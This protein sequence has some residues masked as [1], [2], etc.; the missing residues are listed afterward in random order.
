MIFNDAV[1]HQGHTARLGFTRASTRAVAEVRMR[2]V[3]RRRT[4]RGP[5][6]V[7]NANTAFDVVGL[8][9]VH[10]LRHAGRAARALKSTMNS[11][12]LTAQTGGMHRHAA[13]VVA[14]VF[15]PLQALHEDGNDV[16]GRN[17]ADD[18]THREH[19]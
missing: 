16:A 3:H 8:D 12:L 19:S 10:Q 6:R 9:L 4:V 15:Q 13:G 17:G 14:T 7:R 1:V 2:V 11:A 5:A 18:A